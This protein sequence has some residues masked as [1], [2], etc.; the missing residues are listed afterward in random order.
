MKRIDLLSA[1]KT[2][3]QESTAASKSLSVLGRMV[4]QILAINGET[5]NSAQDGEI[6][7]H[8]DDLARAPKPLLKA[9]AAVCCH[10]PLL[11]HLIA[12]RRKYAQADRLRGKGTRN[13]EVAL[14]LSYQGAVSGRVQRLKESVGSTPE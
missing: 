1:I 5:E 14:S 8:L 12:A 11:G 9:W 13:L 4:E 2:A 7:R 10:D 3:E 6:G